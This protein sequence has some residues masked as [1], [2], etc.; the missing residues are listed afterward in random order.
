MSS[1]DIFSQELTEQLPA[2]IEEILSIPS[3]NRVYSIAFITTDDFYGFYVS[4]DYDTVDNPHNI[5]EHFEWKHA[6]YPSFLYQ[7]LVDIVEA[8][9]IDFTRTSDEKWAFAE[10]L[11]VLLNKHIQA[12]SHEVFEKYGYQKENILFFTTMSDGDYMDELLTESAKLFNQ[13]GTFEKYQ[14]SLET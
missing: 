1:F 12:L 5:W 8:S 3:E 6:I 9:T 11:M 10:Q 4:F 14:I 7:T 2:V 13:S